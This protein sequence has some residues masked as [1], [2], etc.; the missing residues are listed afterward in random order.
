MSL[1][2]LAASTVMLVS[3]NAL[4]VDSL[5]W[6]F[7]A[8]HRPKGLTAYRAGLQWDWNKR[9]LAN[10]WMFVN[11]YWDL[12]FTYLQAHYGKNPKS[13]NNNQVL[14]F[15]PMFRAQFGD[16]NNTITPFIQLG[17]GPSL[18]KNVYFGNLNISSSFQFDDRL[19]FGVLFGKQ[20]QFEL[21]YMYNHLSNAGIKR[22]NPGIDMPMLL[23]FKYHF[24]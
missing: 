5:S 13:R 10:Q 2:F 18:V 22:P 17:V 6:S 9:W 21:S 15:V 3:V 14:S 11:G 23:T 7:G 12:D 24:I 8:G 4:A 20:K 16:I 19:G 1:K